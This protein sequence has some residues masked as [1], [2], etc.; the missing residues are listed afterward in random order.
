M[1]FKFWQ[2]RSLEN[3]ETPLSNP[4]SWLVGGMGGETLSPDQALGLTPVYNAITIIS[5]TVAQLPLNLHERKDGNTEIARDNPLHALVSVKPFRHYGS[6]HWR[7]VQQANALGWGNGWAHIERN[8]R[9]DAKALRLLDP[10]KTHA[11]LKNGEKI[12]VTFVNNKPFVLP[13]RDVLHIPAMSFD[14]IQGKSPITVAKDAITSADAGQKYGKQFFTNGASWGST[15]TVPD[16]YGTENYTAM[17][18][19][20]E[21]YK[22]RGYQGTLVLP[23]SA[24]FNTLSMSPRDAQFIEGRQ[25]AILEVARMFN[26]PA[27]FLSY[28]EKSSFSNVTEMSARLIKYT[29]S[30]WL[31]KWEEEL[32]R[33]L[34]NDTQ[35]KKFFFKFN[36]GGLLRGNLKE[37]YDAY[38]VGING[39]F[40]MRNEA[41]GY[42]DL[43][44]IDGL[45]EPMIPLN[46]VP[47]SEL[48]KDLEKKSTS[49]RFESGLDVDQARKL[50]TGINK[51]LV[52]DLEEDR[53]ISPLM[54]LIRDLSRRTVNIFEKVSSK[55]KSK[56]AEELSSFI[57]R[58][59]VPMIETLCKIRGGDSCQ[60]SIELGEWL[61][62]KEALS[63]DDILNKLLEVGQ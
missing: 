9:G 40:I 43:S 39:G 61:E 22:G 25:F 62:Q 46:M 58:N 42:E 59:A 54:P 45:S 56:R 32:S 48:G 41:R 13:D 52:E 12:I 50:A 27:D 60:Q 16:N 4:A 63:E 3:P 23:A 10:S 38:A 26:I 30:P 44:E 24:V 17:K 1:N 15:V 53:S 6:F 21:N 55:E 5:E 33:K 8:G 34:L 49:I 35:R 29:I 36:T 20:I 2:K 7:Q 31:R 19:A 18:N 37:R 47:Q 57:V 11:E 51:A 28:L 14:G